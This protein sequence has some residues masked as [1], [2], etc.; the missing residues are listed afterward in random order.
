LTRAE[1]DP[2]NLELWSEIHGKIHSIK[3][4]ARALSMDN[5]SGLCHYMEGWAK[6]FQQAAMKAT[7]NAIQLLFDGAEL[8]G[9][10]AARMDKVD[11]F[12]HEKWYS[13]LAARFEKSPEQSRG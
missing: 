3:G 8:L 6:L 10:L 1:R 13:G 12:E 4:M 11:S 5:I 7:P 9:F 2:F